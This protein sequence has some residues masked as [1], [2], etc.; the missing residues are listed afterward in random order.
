MTPWNTGLPSS[1][2]VG[3]EEKAIRTDYRVALD[4]FLALTDAELDD[5]NKLMEV[6]EMLYIDD[7]DPHDW[8]EAVE[9][10]MWYLRGGIEDRGKKNPQL[11]SWAQDFPYIAS[12]ISAVVGKDIR[13]VEM[14]WWSFLSAYM[15]IGDCM[16]AQIVRIRDLKARGKRLDKLDKDFYRRNK[17]IIDIQKPLT[18]AEEEILKEWM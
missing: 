8:K 10:A 6:L 4:C 14:H 15:A 16:F 3:G 1:L 18:E 13:S 5:Y 12:P 17:D 7:I 11:V 2:E 9:Q